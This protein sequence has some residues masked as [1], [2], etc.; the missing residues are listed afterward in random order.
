MLP[1]VCWWLCLLLVDQPVDFWVRVLGTLGAAA[2]VALQLGCPQA[3]AAHGGRG[4]HQVVLNK[5]CVGSDLSVAV[6][7]LL[8]TCG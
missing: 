8:P 4:G 2:P 1:A 5:R 6:Y 3:R 7:A